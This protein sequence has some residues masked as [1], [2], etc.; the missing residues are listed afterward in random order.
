MSQ[1]K[2]K[3]IVTELVEDKRQVADPIVNVYVRIG[4]GNIY[5]AQIAVSLR[6]KIVASG[7][8]TLTPDWKRCSLEDI[9]K[10]RLAEPKD[11]SPFAIANKAAQLRN[12]AK[13][14]KVQRAKMYKNGIA[15]ARRALAE[16]TTQ[17]S[18]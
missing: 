15:A 18:F 2:V 3:N 9:P 17:L 10:T 6:N 12:K 14:D 8:V 16:P 11:V 5:T 1:G 7:K 4:N 13:H